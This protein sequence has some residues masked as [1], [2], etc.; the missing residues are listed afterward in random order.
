MMTSVCTGEGHPGRGRYG[1]LGRWWE[2]LFLSWVLLIGCC[3]QP[4]FGDFRDLDEHPDVGPD[5]DAPPNTPMGSSKDGLDLDFQS[6]YVPDADWDINRDYEDVDWRPPSPVGGPPSP[7]APL[8]DNPMPNGT[9]EGAS[10][11][12]G[13]SSHLTP[14]GR[15]RLVAALPP[16]QGAGSQTRCPDVFRCTNGVWRWLHQNQNQ[17]EQ[18]GELGGSVSEL[19]EELRSHRRRL[20]VLEMQ[21]EPGL[22]VN[23]TFDLWLRSLALRDA[24]TDTLL[25]VHAA[26]L[27]DLQA[28]IGNLSA[29]AI[30][31]GRRGGRGTGC[32]TTKPLLGMRDTPPPGGP[33]LSFCQ[34][35]CASLYHSGV[36]L[37]GVYQ[38]VLSPGSALPVY[39]DMDTEGGGWTM[40]Q[41]RRDGSLGFNRGWA[42]YRGGFGEPRGEH[43]LGNHALHRLSNHGQHSLRID[44]QDWSH[45]HRHASYHT[46]R[47]EDEDNRYRLHVSGF[48]GT[49]DDSFGW[50]H[51]G[52]AFSTPDTGNVCAEIGHAGWWFHQCFRANLNGVYYQGGR[53]SQRAHNLLGPDG[54]VWFSWKESDFYSLKAV[55]M[56]IRP[57]LFRPR[58]SP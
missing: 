44:L 9:I 8:T 18:L 54:I 37:S 42:E 14:S 20:K 15:C 6:R 36:R 7:D 41:R 27:G 49:V 28:Q 33:L 58:P 34:S 35:D 30:T 31:A 46:F 16:V 55:T 3:L 13:G 25:Q 23:S 1:M 45:T 24:Q 39:C 40:F 47:I 53:Y 19:Q 32:M 22:A 12:C 10:A 17:R 2:P 5:E 50:Y 48:S 4:A 43:W 57:R 11:P 52:H 21:G 56:M 29:A 51:D 38:V 26:L